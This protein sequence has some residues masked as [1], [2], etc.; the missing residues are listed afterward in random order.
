MTVER[1]CP[2]CQRLVD[3]DAP[4]GLCVP[5]LLGTGLMAERPEEVRKFG[6]Y[7]LLQEVG[8]GGMGVVWKAQQNDLNRPVALKMIL[9]GAFASDATVRRFKFEAQAAARLEH[10]NIV[11]IYEV[12]ELDGQHYFTMRLIEGRGLDKWGC[13]VETA[14]SKGV[15]A[16]DKKDRRSHEEGAARMMGKV[17]RAVHF[18]HE[19]GILHRDLKLSNVLVDGEG[20]PWVTDF[21]LAKAL[22]ME[23]SQT[24]TKAVVGSIHYMAPEQAEPRGERGDREALTIAADT[25]SL[26]VILYE[27]LTGRVPF[28]GDTPYQTLRMAIEQ[29]PKLPREI[30]PALDRDLEA[31]CLKCLEKDPQRR[32]ATAQ[33][34][35]EDLERWLKGERV[36]VRPSSGWERAVDRGSRWV[37]RSP[38]RAILLGAVLLTMLSAGLTSFFYIRMLAYLKRPH[39]I[40]EWSGATVT[41][42]MFDAK[43][44]RCSRNFDCSS[45]E[46]KEE[47]WARVEFL[48]VSREWEDRMRVRIRGDIGGWL[49]PNRSPVLTNGQVFLLESPSTFDRAYYLVEVGEWSTSQLLREAPEV[50]IRVSLVGSEGA[51]MK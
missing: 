28:K 22:D 5:C 35:A 11:P 34:L 50:A 40:V 10:P 4:M 43:G 3:A 9:A 37:K 42:P 12:G 18:A 31:V 33:G 15:A 46:A 25:Y 38:V 21:G 51:G 39:R 8:R 49:D 29:T 20:E 41:P 13:E 17:A 45:L 32:Y 23:A 6:T 19:R 24:D 27:L 14:R 26:G 7:D 1:Y 48:N 30:N 2:S 44:R 16:T 47:Q 36:S